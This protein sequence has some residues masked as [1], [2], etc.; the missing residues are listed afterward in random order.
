MKS[1]TRNNSANSSTLDASSDNIVQTEETLD[2]FSFFRLIFK[3]AAPLSSVALMMFGNAFYT[4]FLSLFLDSKGYSRGDIGI[5]QSAYFLGMLVGGIRMESVIRRVGH[6]QALTVF[7][8]LAT[9]SILLQAMFQ[10]FYLWAVLRF[11]VGLSVASI[12][13]VIE[14]WMLGHSNLKSRGI[15]LAL[16]M[17]SLYISQS[18]SQQILSVVDVTSYTP[19]LLCALFTSLSTIP[20][21]LSTSKFKV[22]HAH[23]PL[24]MLNIAKRSPFGVAGCIMSGM[25]LSAIYTFFPLLALSRDVP[26]ENLM[27]LTIFGGV[28]L[29]WPI[30]KLSDYFERRKTLLVVVITTLLL[31]LGGYAFKGD[32]LAGV[33]IM[34]FL[35]GGLSFT[36]YPLCITQVCDQLDHSDITKATAL[37]LVAYG[38]GSVMGPLF[39]SGMIELLGIDSVFLY[40]ALLLTVL[41]TIGIYTSIKKPV[42][43]LKDQ[44]PFMPLNNVTPVACEMDP[45]GDDPAT[46]SI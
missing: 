11:I 14:S 43:P 46:E 38:C 23:S 31:A 37:L 27:T 8:S 26:P 33:Y 13:I 19:F 22:E 18:M 28:L 16:Y 10:D 12:Y 20:V 5:I 34:T 45:R 2:Y 7:G 32:S 40:F 9:S 25:M 29:Q 44:N 39:S 1:I 17:M 30:G 21:G 3:F 15:V 41:T 42:I 24:G 6:I 36:L 4:T 35:F